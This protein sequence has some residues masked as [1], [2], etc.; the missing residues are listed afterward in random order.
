MGV[1]PTMPILPSAAVN[2]LSVVPGRLSPAGV[3]YPVRS[4][5]HARKRGSATIDNRR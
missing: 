3:R 1:I 4:C 5:P 2:W